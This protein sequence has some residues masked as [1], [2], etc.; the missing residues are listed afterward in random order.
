MKKK[1]KEKS[2]FGRGEESALIAQM[3]THSSL[4]VMVSFGFCLLVS[5]IDILETKTKQ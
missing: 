2:L 1:E 4:M 3:V 5:C